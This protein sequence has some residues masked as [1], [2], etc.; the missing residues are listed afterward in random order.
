M[1]DQE[2]IFSPEI[3]V[4]KE[5]ET[6]KNPADYQE[7]NSKVGSSII[8]FIQTFVLFGAIFAII[9]LFVA[10]PH[11]V[12]GSSMLPTYQ[13]GNYILTDKLSYRFGAPQHGDVIVLKNPKN[14]SQDFIKRIMGVPGDKVKVSNGKVYINDQL[15]NE[16]YLPADRRSQYGNFLKENQDFQVPNDQY[17]VMGDNREHSSDSRE[18]GTITKEEI[19]GKVFFRY[20]PVNEFGLATQIKLPT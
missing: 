15:K 7:T 20:W 8:D 12:S 11:K 5:K 17:F 13:D 19:V 14:E 2:P 1:D 3:P 9:Y 4:Q 16:P 6:D 10:Q 18:W